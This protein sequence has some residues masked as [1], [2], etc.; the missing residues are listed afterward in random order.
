[1]EVVR[2]RLLEA[3]RRRA[4][5]RPGERGAVAFS[6]GPDSL[7]LLHLLSSLPDEWALSLCA[8]VV[9]HGL[10]ESSGGEARRAAAIAEGLGV[11]VEVVGA[12]LAADAAGNLEQR[13]REARYRLLEQRLEARGLSWVATGHTA[14]D[15]AE[16][17]LMRMVRGAGLS[18]LSGMPWSRPLGAGLLIRPLLGCQRQELRGYLELHGLDP[19]TDPTNE[20]DDFFRNRVRRQVLPL[21]VRENPKVVEALCRLAETCREESEALDWVAH[22]TLDRDRSLEDDG[23]DTS[24]L[25]G[26]PPGLLFRVLGLAHRD[27]VGSSR[28]L[29]RVHLEAVAALLDGEDHGT[30]GVDIPAA[31]VERRYGRLCWIPGGGAVPGPPLGLTVLR[32]PGEHPLPDGRVLTVR[33]QVV[34]PEQDPSSVLSPGAVR[35]PLVVRACEPGDR[36]AVGPGEHRRVSRVLI[37]AKVARAARARVPVLLQQDPPLTLMVVGIRRAFGAGVAPGEEGLIVEVSTPAGRSTS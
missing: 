17:V 6:G 9:D 22:R 24:Q 2:D 31:R 35:F 27:A 15:Q 12:G 23:I 7:C 29:E 25:R 26:L 10:R 33:R 1:M 36:I 34:T 11:E 18:G 19:V 30:R 4:L 14:T 20:T 5:I 21:L 37:D 13:A 8:V 16:T 28:Q 32:A 3:I